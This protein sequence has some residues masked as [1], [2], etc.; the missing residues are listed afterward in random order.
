MERSFPACEEMEERWG[1]KG[2]RINRIDSARDGQFGTTFAIIVL[3][4]EMK[5]DTTLSLHDHTSCPLPHENRKV[6]RDEGAMIPQHAGQRFPV[7]V[8]AVLTAGQV[9]SATLPL[10]NH[11]PPPPPSL[12]LPVF[13]YQK[14]EGE[15]GETEGGDQLERFNSAMSDSGPRTCHFDSGVDLGHS[16]AT[17]QGHV[18][19]RRTVSIW[20]ILCRS[21]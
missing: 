9:E 14:M 18:R 4:V 19:E 20:G 15:D 11:N 21:T 12:P 3:T 17:I 16:L 5:R 7:F 2:G 10:H 1:R 6:E 13:L 8:I